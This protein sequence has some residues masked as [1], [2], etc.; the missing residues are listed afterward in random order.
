MINLLGFGLSL[1]RLGSSILDLGNG[2]LGLSL[3]A[4]TLILG[5]LCPLTLVSSLARPFGYLKRGKR[6]LGDKRLLG[7]D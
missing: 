3:L 7:R 4:L 2:I 1:P 5:H 6:R